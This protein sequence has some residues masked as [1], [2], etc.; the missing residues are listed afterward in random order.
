MTTLE[1]SFPVNGRIFYYQIITERLFE[2]DK[3]S[4]NINYSKCML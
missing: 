2:G 3:K 1:R 4:M